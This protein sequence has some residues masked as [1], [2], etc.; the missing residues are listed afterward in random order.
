MN[1]DIIDTYGSILVPFLNGKRVILSRD[2][3]NNIWQLDG[4]LKILKREVE[5]KERSF[6]IGTSSEFEPEKRDRNYTT[7]TFLNNSFETKKPF[8]N[9]SNH[10]ASK[11]L[12]VINMAARKQILRH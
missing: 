4:V 7:S 8:G 6:S 9:L 12:K 11:C 3:Q 2:F 5:A 10:P 1:I